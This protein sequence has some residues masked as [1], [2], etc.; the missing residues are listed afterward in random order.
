MYFFPTQLENSEVFLVINRFFKSMYV[1]KL[2][3][4]L[5]ESSTVPKKLHILN[6]KNVYS[7]ISG[8]RNLHFI[9]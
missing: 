3:S 2:M 5:W 6:G 8:V 9:I 4:F 7:F 1:T